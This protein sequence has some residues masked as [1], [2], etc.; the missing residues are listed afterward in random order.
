MSTWPSA[1]LILLASIERAVNNT[2]DSYA[3]LE[4]F[5]FS[6]D[7]KTHGDH[8][9]TLYEEGWDFS[10]LGLLPPDDGSRTNA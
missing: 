8:V 2:L 4:G 7:V 3:E 6:V 1:V 9:A 5:A 10:G